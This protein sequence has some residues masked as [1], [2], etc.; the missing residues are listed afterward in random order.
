MIA[1]IVINYRQPALTL[2]CL[3]SLYAHAGYPFHLWLVDNAADT[4]S[5]TL[6]GDFAARHR[7]VT[8]LSNDDNLGFAGACNQAIELARQDPRCTAVALLNND[9][10]VT[11]D[12]L[13]HMARRLEPERRI[14]MVASRMMDSRDPEQ[15]DSLG[16]VLYKSGIASNRKDPTEPLLGPCG[17]AALYSLDLLD[18]ASRAAG[19]VFDPDFFCYAEDTDLALRARLLGFECALADDAIVYHLGSASSG[20]RHNEFVAYQVLR[21]SLFFMTKNLPSAFFARNALAMLAMQFAVILKY[22]I[23]GKPG[24]VWRVYRDFARGYAR[25]RQHRKRIKAFTQ[26][27][28]ADWRHFVSPR[29]FDQVYLARGIRSLHRRDIPPSTLPT[30]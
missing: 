7:N 12:W 17:G 3:D 4:H 6:L 15:I 14:G 1:V 16:I 8:L 5:R 20:G 10:L 23:K 27:H 2:N 18:S 19:H 22:H 11:P 9:T 26:E 13:A 29:F 28:R 21:N 30:K 25:M 24:I